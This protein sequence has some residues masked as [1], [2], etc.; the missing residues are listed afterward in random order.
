MRRS[1][2]PH[3][4]PDFIRSAPVA[5]SAR[6]QSWRT[7]FSGLAHKS[8]P[9]PTCAVVLSAPIEGQKATSVTPTSR[10]TRTDQLLRQTRIHFPRFEEAKVKITPLEQC[11]SDRKV[12]RVR[13]AK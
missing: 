9:V 10:T 2:P 13:C 1:I 7:Q 12:Y 8:L 6:R 11:G 4:F 5:A 3:S